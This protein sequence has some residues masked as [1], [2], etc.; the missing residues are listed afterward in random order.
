MYIENH[1]E[2][3]SHKCK[4]IQICCIS[5]S[6]AMCYI[7]LCDAVFQTAEQLLIKLET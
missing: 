7:A 6:N 3:N 2:Y 5:C 1:R 4:P